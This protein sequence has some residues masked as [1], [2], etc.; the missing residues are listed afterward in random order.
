MQI[1]NK[2]FIEALVGKE[3]SDQEVF[4][5]MGNLVGFYDLL[6]RINERNNEKN[7][8]QNN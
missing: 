1:D 6:Y 3:L 7:N 8:E 2:Q 5:T 4:E